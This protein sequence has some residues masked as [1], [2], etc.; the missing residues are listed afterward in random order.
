MS[1]KVSIITIIVALFVFAIAPQVQASATTAAIQAG[2]DRVVSLQDPTDGDPNDGKW[3]W[4]LAGPPTY[5]NITGPIG[6]GLLKAY[7]VL[8]DA[9]HLTSAKDA[10]DSLV[11]LTD[12]WV[13]TFN[14]SFLLRLY[15]A[16]GDANYQAQAESFFDALDDGTY[17]GSS[18]TFNTAGYIAAVQTGR[19]GAYI[20]LRPW[21]FYKLSYASNRVG[22]DVDDPL[23][24]AKFVQAMK[25]GV[26][27]LDNNEAWDLLG[28]AGA[29][30]GMSLVGADHDPLVGAFAS[31][32]SLAD[33]AA[34][35]AA[36]QNPN[37][38]WYWNSNLGAP[39]ADDEDLQ[40]TAYAILALDEYNRTLYATEITAARRYLVSLQG[41]SG[42]GAG[43]WPSY[44]GGG[45]NIEVNAEVVWALST[46]PLPSAGVAGLTLLG[47]VGMRRRR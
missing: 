8:G 2:A 9:A 10:G 6:L 47:A 36:N 16:S 31:D 46:I 24:T 12:K 38:S 27:T 26:D 30:R 43:G 1:R 4:P 3:G 19:D 18:G 37:G 5:N 40:T 7:T 17:V 45:E 35:L 25:D 13:G 15:D 32:D 41:T 44:P 33:L 28:L 21:E 29:V 20:N 34:T 11:G 39:A 23:Q 42:V 14:P 22:D